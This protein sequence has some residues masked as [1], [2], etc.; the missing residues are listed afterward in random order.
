MCY[1]LRKLFLGGLTL[2]LAS[3]A[4]TNLRYLGYTYWTGSTSDPEVDYADWGSELHQ[5]EAF[6]EPPVYIKSG[7]PDPF[8]LSPLFTKIKT[9]NTHGHRLV[10]DY[11]YAKFCP[12]GYVSECDIK[13]FKNIMLTAVKRN[14]K[15]MLA[16]M[17]EN[18][19]VYKSLSKEWLPVLSAGVKQAVAGVP[20]KN[21][22]TDLGGWQIF[23]PTDG[24]DTSVVN[25]RVEERDNGWLDILSPE[26]QD[27]VSVK[28]VYIGKNMTPMIAGV[29]NKRM[30]IDILDDVNGVSV[31]DKR[32][33]VTP[34]DDEYMYLQFLCPM[35]YKSVQPGY[36]VTDDD[37]DRFKDKANTIKQAFVEDFYS[38]VLKSGNDI[39]KI[40]R[41]YRNSL[42]QRFATMTD[43]RVHHKNYSVDIFLPCSYTEFAS[44][45]YDVTYLGKD[46]YQVTAGSSNLKLKVVLYGK[47]LTPAIMG[48]FNPSQNINY[49][50]VRFTWLD[51]NNDN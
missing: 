20:N 3:C 30:N 49:C 16:S 32:L 28:V 38:S 12:E 26:G 4:E 47:H 35:L 39:R 37:F 33:A 19:Y 50:P 14:L 36:I 29:R 11:N 1:F 27:T 13:D 6:A 2:V 23:K 25:Y 24:V 44:C 18:V 41:K 8:L 7:A 34:F 9:V 46:W 10:R 17:N 45:N 51:D 40:Q 48:M 31:R 21:H 15:R 42:V 5:N 43:S 22:Y